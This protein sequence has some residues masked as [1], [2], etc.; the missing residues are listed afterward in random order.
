MC[1]AGR[2]EPPS[3]C[4]RGGGRV[5]SGNG[6]CAFLLR[7]FSFAHQKKMLKNNHKLYIHFVGEG[8]R[9]L[10]IYTSGVRQYGK[11]V[12]ARQKNLP[13]NN[14]QT[15]YGRFTN[16]PTNQPRVLES[17]ASV[18]FITDRASAGSSVVLTA[19]SMGHWPSP[20]RFMI[21]GTTSSHENFI[22]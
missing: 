12:F 7:A 1:R 8:L 17:L 20:L 5:S 6:S 2:K 13:K 4:L 18:L 15:P 16:R 9:A 3:A 10:P 21:K 11:T 22:P 19:S 14:H